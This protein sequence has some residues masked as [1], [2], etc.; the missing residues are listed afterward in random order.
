MYKNRKGWLKRRIATGSVEPVF[1]ENLL[2]TQDENVE[3]S[4]KDKVN[5]VC[6][7]ANSFLR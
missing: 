7:E 2:T 5:K 1:I 3:D 6:T 4:E